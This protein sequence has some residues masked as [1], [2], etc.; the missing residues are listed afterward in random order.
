MK[1][2]I[3]AIGYEAFPR[4]H[5]RSEVEI[6][7]DILEICMKGANK[8]KIVYA[9]NLNF[10]RLERYLGML[11]SLGFVAAEDDP[12][13]SVVYRTTKAGM[14]FLCGCLKMQE[15]LRKLPFEVKSKV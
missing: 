4:G 8:T 9:A 5:R 13:G 3:Y 15:S 14:D 12:A 7:R 6:M 11:L 2:K 10:S 1:K